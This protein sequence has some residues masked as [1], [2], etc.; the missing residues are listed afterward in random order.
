MS[1]EKKESGNEKRKLLIFSLIFAPDGVSTA[2]LLTDMALTLQHL[3][4]EITVLTGTPSYNPDE[5]AAERQPLR[6]R[7]GGL[8][9]E[10]NLESVRVYHVPMRAKKSRITSR[11]IDYLLFH[12]LSTLFGALVIGRQDLIFSISPPLSIG[13]NARILAALKRVPFIYDVQ[14]IFPDVMTEMGLIRSKRLIA[15]LERMEKYVYKHADALAVISGSFRDILEAK[16]V[17]SSKIE[18]IHNFV[19][20]DFIEPGDRYNEFSAKHGLDGKF[21]VQYAGNIGLYQGFETILSAAKR[22]EKY[23]DIHFLLVGGGSRYEWLEQEIREANHRNVSLLP[24][25]PHEQIPLILAAS[26]I[27][28]VPLRGDSSRWGLPSKVYSIMGAARPVLASVRKDSELARLIDAAGCGWVVEPDDPDALA[29]RLLQAYD[30]RAD[31]H[32][33]GRQ[34]RAFVEE[35]YDRGK[36]CKQYDELFKRVMARRA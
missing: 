2:Q 21:V 17:S 24:Y 14:E 23:P 15:G 7:W 31:L 33:I 29:D 13:V 6:K 16:G 36:I 20:V 3:G 25:H 11:I 34:G 5:L 9:F 30:K 26:D 22:L 27:C 35:N 32:E 19:D 8:L 28:L 1:A 12:L 4:Y 10:S 18:V